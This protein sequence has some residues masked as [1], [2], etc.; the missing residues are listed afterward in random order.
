MTDLLAR[1]DVPW[2]HSDS[3][4]SFVPKAEVDV[5]GQLER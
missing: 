5:F 3:H 4:V 2:E 1:Y